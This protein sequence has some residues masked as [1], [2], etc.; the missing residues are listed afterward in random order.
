MD[1]TDALQQKIQKARAQLSSDTLNAIDAIPWQ[2][3]I[4][5]M[6]E[7]KGYTFEQLGDLETETEL[8][9]AGIINPTEYSRELEKRMK[10]SRT[11]AENLVKEMNEQVFSKIRDELIKII[12]L[13]KAPASEK[14]SEELPLIQKEEEEVL[15]SA[16]I[17]LLKTPATENLPQKTSRKE[18]SVIKP[19]ISQPH[20][21]MIEKLS[22]VSQASQAATDHS[23]EKTGTS[24]TGYP[25]G[26]DPY[27]L[28]P[29]L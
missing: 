3:T 24:S 20:P 13:K 23:V 9:L 4:L 17:E 21:I 11:D 29:E 6:R 28:P 8:L 12:E 15:N 2:A 14:P 22:Q 1:G 25:K 18:E 26:A 5:K 16:G 19:T 27:R 7:T 10:I